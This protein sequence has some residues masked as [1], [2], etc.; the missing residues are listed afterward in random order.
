MMLATPVRSSAWS[1]TRSTLDR[2]AATD[3]TSAGDMDL[4][5]QR[6]RLPGE[7][8]LRAVAG[9]R[10]DRQRCADPLGTLVHAGHAEPVGRRL[11]RDAAAV[12]SDGKPD[13][14]RPR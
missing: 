1:A 4:G 6:R 14:E 9:R 12:V 3:V 5:R 11:L 8:D 7:D 2:A 10:D 13:S